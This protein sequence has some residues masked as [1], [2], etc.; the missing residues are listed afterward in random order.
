MIS[1][2]LAKEI[3]LI[4]A[5]FSGGSTGI[6]DNNGL[7][8]ALNRPY[9]TFDGTDLYPTGIEKSA[10]ILESIIINHPFIDGNKRIGYAFMRLLLAEDGFDMVAH[11]DE[12][13]HFIIS[14]SK[15]HMKIE[16]IIT[17]IKHHTT[18]N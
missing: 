2:K 13:Y 1:D 17:W 3:N 15:G 18:K 11:E 9:Q 14:V 6:R 5:K 12:I 16:E 8:S 7:H 4:I 10:A